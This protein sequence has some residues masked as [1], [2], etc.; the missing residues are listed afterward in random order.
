MPR[1][2]EQVIAEYTGRP[3]GVIGSISRNMSASTQTLLTFNTG[4]A[5]MLGYQISISGNATRRANQRAAFRINRYQ[6][7]PTTIGGPIAYVDVDSDAA[8]RSITRRNYWI[9]M[10]GYRHS[11]RRLPL[12]TV[13]HILYGLG[14][15]GGAYSITLW[16]Y[17][18]TGE[19]SA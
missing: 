19:G 9:P 17:F 16:R 15:Q 8:T 2:I 18:P 4:P 11:G 6:E 10:G 3:I 7:R 14:M 1:A 13:G 5:L 12:P